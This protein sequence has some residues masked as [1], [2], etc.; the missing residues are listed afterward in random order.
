MGLKFFRRTGTLLLAASIMPCGVLLANESNQPP[1]VTSSTA[2]WYD[3]EQAS[4]LFTQM[5]ALAL[6]VR[7]DVGR[8]QAQG[9]Q[10]S[11]REHG[12]RLARAK[13][14][15][16]T[17]GDDLMQLSEMKNRLEP[18]QRSLLNKVPPDVH[19]MVYQMDEALNTLDSHQDRT[20]L[21]MTQYPQNIGEIYDSANQMTGTIRTVTQYAN[22][23]EKMAAL[24][25]RKGAES[26]S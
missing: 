19:E 4:N 26:G 13:A 25:N 1:A 5:N 22:A 18:W 16:N 10:L 15:I 3:V 11:W 21:A 6:K 20:V 23:E 2:N 12:A 9:Y 7:R 8:L 14:N 24:T 17:I